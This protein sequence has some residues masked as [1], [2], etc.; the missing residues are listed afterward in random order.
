MTDEPKPIHVEGLPVTNYDEAN[1]AFFSD[2]PA[3]PECGDEP[4][5]ITFWGLDEDGTPCVTIDQIRDE[6]GWR[7]ATSLDSKPATT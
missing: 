6:N 2:D 7:R 4:R 5:R 3:L 1:A